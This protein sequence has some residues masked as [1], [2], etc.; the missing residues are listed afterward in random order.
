MQRFEKRVS[1][2]NA[3]YINSHLVKHHTKNNH[4]CPQ[5][6][7]YEVIDGEFGLRNG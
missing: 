3:M 7:K 6:D 1:D 4:Q 2:H 5:I